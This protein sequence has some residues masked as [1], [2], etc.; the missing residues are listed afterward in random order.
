V[1]QIGAT[2]C[3]EQVWRVLT[4]PG[5]TRRFLGISLQ[6]EWAVGSRI[7]GSL[8]GAPMMVGEVLFTECPARLSYMLAIDA[9][10][11]EI[12]V[13]WSYEGATAERSSGSPWTKPTART[14]KS[15][16][17]RGS[18]SSRRCRPCSRPHRTGPS[19]ASTSTESPTSRLLLPLRRWRARVGLVPG[20]RVDAVVRPLP[21]GLEP[22]A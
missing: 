16:R 6:S 7:S 10:H 15:S 5:T 13:T 21:N 11:P 12:Y 20:C 4:N 1:F 8:D 3:P 17:P 19:L 2:G 18:Q 22:T 14:P 9:G